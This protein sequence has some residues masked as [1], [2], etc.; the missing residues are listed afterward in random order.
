MSDISANVTIGM[1]SQL[2]TAAR[3]F[4]ELANGKIYIGKIDTDPTIPENQIQVYIEN[5]DGSLVPVPQPIVINAGGF[6]V[7]NGQIA[8]FVTVEG[9][10]M[11]VYDSFNA[12]QFYFHN[13]YDP[14]QFSK[15]ILSID[16][17]SVIGGGF[18]S[19]IR[20]YKGNSN[21]IKCTGR[22][23]LFDGAY[24]T[25]AL[26]ISD[27]ASSDN[28][29]TVLVDGMGR[30]WKRQY[31]GYVNILWFGNPNDCADAFNRAFASHDTVY[32]P[33]SKFIAKSR[34]NIP[35]DHM[36]VICDE[37]SQLSV[38]GDHGFFGVA[39]QFTGQYFSVQNAEF[40][41][42]NV[43]MGRGFH[44][45]D[46]NYL[47]HLT[48][49]NCRF[50]QALKFGIDAN[51]IAINASK[52]LF[53]NIG[54]N[55][56]P[57]Q[58]IRSIGS[59]SS[60]I[61]ASNAN[62]FGEG[63][64]FSSANGSAYVVQIENGVKCIFEDVFIERNTTTEGIFRIV[65]L[66]LPEFRRCWWE[67]NSTNSAIQLSIRNGIDA[68]M[69][70]VDGCQIDS[71]TAF[72]NAV[73]DWSDTVNKNSQITNNIFARGS[74]KLFSDNGKPTVSYGNYSTTSGISFTTRKTQL[75]QLEVTDAQGVNTTQLIASANITSTAGNQIRGVYSMATSGVTS[76]TT[77]I[78]VLAGLGGGIAIVR[79]ALSNGISYV[80]LYLVAIKR[81]GGGGNDVEALSVSS[82]P[83]SATGE[84]TFDNSGGFLRINRGTLTGSIHTTIIGL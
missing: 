23:N 38:D 61:A 11:A 6:P 56:G 41:T 70:T 62:R 49:R 26:D 28:G 66:Y 39:S 37:K 21:Q 45:Q 71:G 20:S 33:G 74:G 30:R 67:L 5:E 31:D 77:D 60:P 10:S 81:S 76:V 52:C 54:N 4:K 57:M 50:N 13:I 2:F 40:T 59:F 78:P 46:Y 79:G 47:S 75:A 22:S 34:I 35:R 72:T 15:Q 58:A 80:K 51:L 83:A 53:G 36:S 32:V 9:H 1:P 25:F 16:G 65:G 42:E 27:T 43:G 8:K 55:S 64:R 12:Q 82:A 18:Y 84:P 73:I 14:Q 48:L 69:L 24:G 63:T 3:S 17:E 7:Y 19:D 68:Q 44:T 29:G